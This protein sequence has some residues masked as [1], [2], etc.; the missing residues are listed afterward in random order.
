M[1]RYG[2][3]WKTMYVGPSNLLRIHSSGVWSHL[4]PR[5]SISRTCLG[6]STCPIPRASRPISWACRLVSGAG[7]HS[8]TSSPTL[9]AL[10]AE[11]RSVEG[12]ES[13]VGLRISRYNRGSK[14]TQPVNRMKIVKFPKRRVLVLHLVRGRR[15]GP[16]SLSRLW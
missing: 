11:H 16:V 2:D 9:P 14:K 1:D 3:T 6:G 15:N 10:L 7:H 4:L 8:P 12:E 5:P 13:L